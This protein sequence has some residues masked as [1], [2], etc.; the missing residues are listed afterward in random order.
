MKKRDG[1]NKMVTDAISGKV[2]LI[3]TKSLSRFARNTVDCL[4]T[5]RKLKEHNVEVYFEKENIYTLDSKGEML[6]A[7]LASFAQQESLSLSSN[8]TWGIRKRFSDGKVSLPY[9]QFLG[10][11]KGEDDLPKIVEE[12]A[13]I[14]RLIYKLFLEGW[15]ALSIAKHLTERGIK[16]PGGKELWRTTTVKSILINE[17]YHGNAILQKSYTVDY[18]TKKKKMNEGEVP[19]YFVEN[20]HPAIV[21][22]EQYLLVQ[23][24]LKRR[25]DTPGLI[26]TANCFSGRLICGDCGSQFGPKVWHSTSKYKRVVWQC[27]HKFQGEKKCRTPHLYED[28]IK[29]AFISVVE[30]VLKNRESITA[31]LEVMLNDVLS[32]G[33]Q[34]AKIRKVKEQI[35]N[36]ETEIKDCVSENARK[37]LNQEE[38]Q[39]RYM[40][41][42]EEY[43]GR[44]QE[45]AMLETELVGLIGR[46]EIIGK[47]LSTIEGAAI[48]DMSLWVV[49]VEK[50]VVGVNGS[51]EFELHDG[52]RFV[53]RF[54]SVSI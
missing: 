21:T 18:L 37:P 31:N 48:A 20:S 12:E 32:P 28:D 40:P 19:K 10:Y 14:I 50:T 4:T 24:E 35:K 5:I 7:I 34:E 53:R 2:E 52:M 8:V 9:K 45:V 44:Q 42:A 23:E 46:R 29:T 26:S 36:L 11:E 1:F 22:Q 25:A 13:K 38:Y 17:K 54:R 16:T 39:M 6:M 47:Y 30:E 49:M 15:S 27:N 41:L 33:E 3:I 51:V 43:E